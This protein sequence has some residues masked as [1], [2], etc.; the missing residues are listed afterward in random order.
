MIS[1]QEAYRITLE[2]I[3]PLAYEEVGLLEATG[4]VAAQD[5]LARV[6]APTV[7]ISLKDGYAVH[8]EDIAQATEEAPAKLTLLGT[9]AAGGEWRSVI[10]RGQT[11]R[12]L[13]GAGVPEEVGAVLA[14][15]YTRRDGDQVFAFTHAKAGR[16]ILPNGSDV[17]KGEVLAHAGEILRPTLV[18]LLAAGG[19]ENIPVVRQ[20][21]VH[22]LATGDEVLAPGEPLV[23]GKLYA[24]NLVTLAAWCCRYGFQVHT[25]VAPDDAETIRTALQDHLA[26]GDALL[27]SGGAW[28]GERDLTVRLL[29]EMGWQKH[30]HRVRI[31]P[32]K[33][34]GFGVYQDKPVFCLPGG[35]P[36][37]HMA[38]IQL[39]LPGLQKL[40]GFARPGLPRQLARLQSEVSGQIDWTQFVHGRL[41]QADQEL[42]FH[43]ILDASRLQMMAHTEAVLAIPEGVERIEAGEM[44]WVQIL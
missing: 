2:N 8:P 3:H 25:Q 21:K 38:F 36:S 39:G 5:L 34:I 31:G 43:P 37:N 4:R 22:I 35:P 42:R 20:P 28:K 13:S 23:E 6:D 19:Y 14:E 27:T 41:E 24:S 30:Y 9:I 32:G 40:A 1:Y 44:V 29:D 15:E 7:N 10:G 16:N 33:A 17:R 18:G 11:V 12:I 26:I